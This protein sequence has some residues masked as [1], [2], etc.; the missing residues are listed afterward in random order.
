LAVYV[1]KDWYGPLNVATGERTE[2]APDSSE[3]L[4]WWQGYVGQPKEDWRQIQGE[5]L[6]DLIHTA[7]GVQRVV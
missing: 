4:I 7:K 3:G 6:E 5:E 1:E 2:F